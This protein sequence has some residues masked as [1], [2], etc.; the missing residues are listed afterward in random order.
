MAIPLLT[1]C[2]ASALRACAKKTKDGPQARR[3][4]A[5]R[6]AEFLVAFPG[7]DR[8]RALSDG[9]MRFNAPHEPSRARRNEKAR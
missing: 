1:D 2:D 8:R 9:P 5:Q 4:L 6:P 3:L 7:D